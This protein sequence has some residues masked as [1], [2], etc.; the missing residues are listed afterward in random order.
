MVSRVGD[1]LPMILPRKRALVPIHGRPAH[2]RAVRRRLIA[3]SRHCLGST[4]L[5][6]GGVV[7]PDGQRL[8]GIQNDHAPRDFTRAQ[9]REVPGALT[10]AGV[11]RAKRHDVAGGGRGFPPITARRK[12]HL[13]AKRGIR[14][15]NGEQGKAACRA[16]VQ[17]SCSHWSVRSDTTTQ[18]HGLGIR[19][20]ALSV[21]NGITVGVARL[22]DFRGRRSS[23]AKGSNH[24][25]AA[26]RF[27][28][29]LP[30][31]HIIV[32]TDTAVQLGLPAAGRKGVDDDQARR[33]SRI[34]HVDLAG[35]HEEQIES[36]VAVHIPGP[37]VARRHLVEPEVACE[38]GPDVELLSPRPDLSRIRLEDGSESAT[39]EQNQPAVAGAVLQLGEPE[40]VELRAWVRICRAEDADWTVN[41]PGIN[42]VVDA[43]PKRVPGPGAIKLDLKPAEDADLTSV[44]LVVEQAHPGFWAFARVALGAGGP[45][46]LHYAF[47][48]MGPPGHQATRREK[49]IRDLGE[50]EDLILERS[51]GHVGVDPRDD[52]RIDHVG[53]HGLDLIVGVDHIGVRRLV[54][55]RAATR[56]RRDDCVGRR[57]GGVRRVD[58]IGT[59]LAEASAHTLNQLAAAEEKKSKKLSAQGRHRNSRARGASMGGCDYLRHYAAF[60]L[61]SLSS[62]YPTTKT[63]QRRIAVLRPLDDRDE[64]T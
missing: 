5:V 22:P 21:V 24:G 39:H 61:E 9:G 57:R 54:R 51:R 35:L 48:R 23:G 20:E 1:H 44:L 28:D 4:L 41:E 7:P 37:T 34:C 59:G 52:V 16:Q 47:R 42:H 18:R 14:R 33:L 6:L 60:I 49:S 8:V 63:H 27:S 32:S 55:V 50:L 13:M 19:R 56:L 40:L 26:A 12:P 3:K 10:L 25:R 36:A 58:G 17:L 43:A 15:R 29:N 46:S 38:R 30:G 2:R 11:N 62:K 45:V 31:V 64:T 53:V